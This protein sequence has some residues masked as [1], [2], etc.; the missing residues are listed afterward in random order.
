MWILNHLSEWEFDILGVGLDV[1]MIRM[2]FLMN[3]VPMYEICDRIAFRVI[4][5]NSL[6]ACLT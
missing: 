1:K 5:R 6:S 3:C 4:I 2:I